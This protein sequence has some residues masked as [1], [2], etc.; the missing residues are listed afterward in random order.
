MMNG[1]ENPVDLQ[2]PR[3]QVFLRNLPERFREEARLLSP[4]TIVAYSQYLKP[5][6]ERTIALYVPDLANSGLHI[7]N[8]LG[9]EI[10]IRGQTTEHRFNPAKAHRLKEFE[11]ADFKNA[12]LK[13]FFTDHNRVHSIASIGSSLYDLETSLSDLGIPLPY[14]RDYF[15]FFRKSNQFP[16]IDLALE[17]LFQKHAGG[18][19][20]Y[21]DYGDGQG[22]RL[23]DPNTRHTQPLPKPG[24]SKIS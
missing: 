6:F 5:G 17:T 11:I 10:Y 21:V 15:S 24:R 12:A 13:I 4:E 16:V 20:Y 1:N 22:I 9:V 8:L 18:I 19:P 23:F 14:A 3:R 2:D 7:A